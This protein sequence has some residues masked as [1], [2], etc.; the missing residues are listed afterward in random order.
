MK[1]NR[2]NMRGFSQGEIERILKVGICL[3]CHKGKDKIYRNWKEK[4]ECPKYPTLIFEN[5]KW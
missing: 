5:K 2:E 3:E 4:I 1:F